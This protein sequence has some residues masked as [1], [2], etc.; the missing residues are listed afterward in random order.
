MIRQTLFVI[1]N[2]LIFNFICSPANGYKEKK[3]TKYA[4]ADEIKRLEAAGLFT[5]SFLGSIMHWVIHNLLSHGMDAKIIA[6]AAEMMKQPTM[7]IMFFVLTVL[8]ATPGFMAFIF[9]GKTCWRLLT[10]LAIVLLTLNGIHY[11]IHIM[12]G[13]VL[14]GVTTFVLQMV[15]GLAGVLFSFK[16]IGSINK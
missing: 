15:P 10:A 3:M 8:G 5:L 7:Q 1:H 9:K 11:I 14:G 2:K 16:Y 6:E 12:N 4:P 13:D